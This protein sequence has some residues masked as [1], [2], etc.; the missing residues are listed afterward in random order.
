[1]KLVPLL[2]ALALSTSAC[3]AHRQQLTNQEVAGFAV[4]A[5]VIALPLIIGLA[6]EESRP[7]AL[8]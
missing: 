6:S 4:I 3:G 8:K 1:M 2:L 5:A 7:P